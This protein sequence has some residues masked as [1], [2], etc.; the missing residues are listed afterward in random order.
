MNTRLLQSEAKPATLQ[1]YHFSAR[2]SLKETQQQEALFEMMATA[3]ATI[4]ET[5]QSVGK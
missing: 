1:F 2:V 5:D 4:S 3:S